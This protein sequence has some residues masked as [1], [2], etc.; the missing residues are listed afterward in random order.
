M[1]F[2]VF[3]SVP[4]NRVTQSEEL[5]KFITFFGRI[6]NYIGETVFS[7]PTPTQVTDAFIDNKNEYFSGSWEVYEQRYGLNLM[8][9]S[10][11]RQG[12]HCRLAIIN[13]N[14][15]NALDRLVEE[16][17]LSLKANKKD[18]AIQRIPDK[19]RGIYGMY[20]IEFLRL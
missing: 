1:E 13:N 19:V 17:L 7:N 18:L 11:Y 20:I 14:P 15:A 3:M 12:G 16:T 2:A 10:L 9:I 6:A 4:R 5:T 8:T